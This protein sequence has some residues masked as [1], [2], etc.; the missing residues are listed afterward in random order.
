MHFD[1]TIVDI[2][3]KEYDPIGAPSNQP[4]SHSACSDT[5]PLSVSKLMVTNGVALYFQMLHVHNFVH[6]DFV[7]LFYDTL[8]FLDI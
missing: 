5:I 1:F 6:A 7:S 2:A 8:C 4:N 3:D